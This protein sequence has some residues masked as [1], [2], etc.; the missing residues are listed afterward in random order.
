M[1]KPPKYIRWILWGISILLLAIGLLA[2]NDER[3]AFYFKGSFAEY[4][5]WFPHFFWLLYCFF[6]L[7]I[8][9]FAGVLVFL[10]AELLLENRHKIAVTK[11]VFFFVSYIV[12][13]LV[14]PEFYPFSKYPMY[15][16]WVKETYVF[17]VRDSSGN[18]IPMDRISS[19]NSAHLSHV[20]STLKVSGM[21]NDSIVGEKMFD[22]LKTNKFKNVSGKIGIYKMNMFFMDTNIQTNEVRFY[23]NKLE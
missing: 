22:V 20:Y 21:Q 16:R 6:K 7:Y 12:F 1:I 2:K 23:E 13:S 9:F 3:F 4:K 11:G 15:S 17:L 8:P 10:S 18:M 5:S 14:L 19:I